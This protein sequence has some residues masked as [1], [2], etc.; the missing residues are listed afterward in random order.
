MPIFKIELPETLSVAIRGEDSVNVET[1]TVPAEMLALCVAYGWQQKNAD[2]ASSAARVAASESGVDMDDEKAVKAWIGDESNKA[3]IASMRR[4]L[5]E[6][7]V[8]DRQNG[9]WATR[10]T[11]TES[12]PLDKY[13]VQVV[14]AYIR[15]AADAKIKDRKTREKFLKLDFDYKQIDSTEQKERRALLLE[16]AN[17]HAD[18]INP[19]AE[20]LKAESEA[21]DLTL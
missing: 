19:R 10:A 18:A 2:A 1:S 21:R 12:D 17:K 16:F 15:A 9:V 14:R 3:A 11:A 20:K 13:R 5:I 7:A 4:T 6:Q 8:E